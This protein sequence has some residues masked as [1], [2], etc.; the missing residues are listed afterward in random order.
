MR[1]SSYSAALLLG[2]ALITTPL[3]GAQAA[4]LGIGDTQD[5]KN[6]FSTLGKVESSTP[7]AATTFSGFEAVQK[8]APKRN[9]QFLTLAPSQPAAPPAPG[10][11][12]APAPGTAQPAPPPAPAPSTEPAPETAELEFYP[13][14]LNNDGKEDAWAADR[15]GD[16]YFDMMLVDENGDG[17]ADYAL[18]DDN[19]N[20]V[21]DAKYVPNVTIGDKTADVYGFDDDEDGTF[22]YYGLDWDQDGEIDEF[23]QA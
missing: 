18:F 2:A 1:F 7:S 19:F 4:D 12:P 15:N 16:G 22:D 21:I 17:Q 9:S 23:Q 13:V 14:D 10:P 3:L 8:G 20:G 5:Q 11:A 6:V